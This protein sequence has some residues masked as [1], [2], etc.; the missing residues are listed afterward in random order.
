MLPITE[1][2]ILFTNYNLLSLHFAYKTELTLGK[3]HKRNVL[4]YRLKNFDAVGERT[5]V[6]QNKPKSFQCFLPG[7]TY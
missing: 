5:P 4:T 6:R 2:H 3:R 1:L 7:Q